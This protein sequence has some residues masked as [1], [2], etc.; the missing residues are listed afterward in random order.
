MSADLGK[1]VG[2]GALV[3]AALAACTSSPSTGAVGPTA[4]TVAGATSTGAAAGPTGAGATGDGGSAT[5]SAAVSAVAPPRET[6]KPS[7]AVSTAPPL[8]IGRTA[9][10]DGQVFVTVGRP[11]A[12]TVTA[13][14]PGEVAGNAVAVSVTVRNAS[15]TA[16][17]AGGISVN[18]AYGRGTGT[19]AAPTDAD[20]A[21]P[22]LTKIAPG[23]SAVGTYVFTAP[24]S[25]L[26]QLRIEVS[27]NAA[28][29]ILVFE[30]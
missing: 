19:P 14:G 24:A 10:L 22:L 26:R 6:A 27:S 4:S 18:A 16:F 5:P 3:V 30:S 2:A 15:A 7:V 1:L 25:A 17:D 9:T 28:A 23:R 12:V 20:P 11:R 8:G 21:R 13:R 29:R